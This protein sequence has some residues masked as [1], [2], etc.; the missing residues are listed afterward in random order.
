MKKREIFEGNGFDIRIAKCG[1]GN[2]KVCV[3]NVECRNESDELVRLGCLVVEHFDNIQEA[4]NYA[5]GL[6]DAIT[7]LQNRCKLIKEENFG[8]TASEKGQA[9]EF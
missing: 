4:L 2:I 8:L 1:N 9:N 7:L 3:E 5:L 6:H